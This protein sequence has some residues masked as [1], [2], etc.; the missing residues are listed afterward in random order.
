MKQTNNKED[1]DLFNLSVSVAG[2]KELKESTDN[3]EKSLLSFR[4]SLI[5]GKVTLTV[6]YKGNT[7]ER[8]IF[9]PQA[10]RL[11]YNDFAIKIFARNLQRSLI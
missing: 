5:K 4:P 9:V 7:T 2:G 6:E 10:R 3:L 1:K 11:F 8:V